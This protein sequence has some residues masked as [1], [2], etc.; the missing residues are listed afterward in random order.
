MLI[1]LQIY[2]INSKFIKNKNI[3]RHGPQ[4]ERPTAVAHEGRTSNRRNP[5]R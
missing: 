5:R 1:I 3:N 4:R 2:M